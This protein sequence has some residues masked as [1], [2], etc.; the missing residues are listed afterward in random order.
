M[1]KL[2]ESGRWTDGSQAGLGR[3]ACRRFLSEEFDP[4][5]IQASI[6]KRNALSMREIVWEGEGN[7]PVIFTLFW[8]QWACV[9]VVLSAAMWVLLLSWQGKAWQ[10]EQTFM[11]WMRLNFALGYIVAITGQTA[12]QIFYKPKKKKKGGGGKTS[13]L[14]SRSKVRSVTKN[15]EC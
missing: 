15:A 7:L 6:Q 3:S 5:Y 12:E 8:N 4:F 10:W 9:T 14:K 11:W 1:R 13:P 2:K